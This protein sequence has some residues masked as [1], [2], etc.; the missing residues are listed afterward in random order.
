[1]VA[2]PGPNTIVA[3]SLAVLT[4]K[5]GEL[6]GLQLPLDQIAGITQRVNLAR[7]RAKRQISARR[8]DAVERLRHVGR[9]QIAGAKVQARNGRLRHQNP[10][11][12]AHQRQ[13]QQCT[14]HGA[15][16][17]RSAKQDLQAQR[18]QQHRPQ[19]QHDGPRIA[20]NVA[21]IAEQQNRADT[22][23][24]NRPKQSHTTF[25]FHC[26]LTEKIYSPVPRP[27]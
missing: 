14:D 8:L 2:G 3:R 4:L 7:A 27:T 5:F 1:M 21:Q 11:D 13:T 15:P 12:A 26:T 6:I 19:L 16:A 23:Q 25:V 22:D 18:D 17:R 20:V 10:Q 9:L 24:D